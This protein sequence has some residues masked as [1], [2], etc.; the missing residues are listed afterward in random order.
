MN[1]GKG[2][3]GVG[4]LHACPYWSEP[5]LQI[6]SVE[7]HW[8][9][10]HQAQSGCLRPSHI[11]SLR[12]LMLVSCG[13]ALQLIFSLPHRTESEWIGDQDCKRRLLR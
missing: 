8:P 6:I 5:H 10:R 9:V 12:Y 4:A 11:G 7:T 1:K 13:A 2:S 3:W